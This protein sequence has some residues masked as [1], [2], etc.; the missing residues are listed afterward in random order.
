MFNSEEQRKRI[1][2]LFKVCLRHSCCI[3]LSRVDDSTNLPINVQSRAATFWEAFRPVA[4]AISVLGS[5]LLF[6]I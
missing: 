2:S 4:V 1:N 6:A 5:T 3:N